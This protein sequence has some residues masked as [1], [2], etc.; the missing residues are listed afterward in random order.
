MKIYNIFE[1]IVEPT[2]SEVIPTGADIVKVQVQSTGSYSVKF[3]GR[4]SP[5]FEYL[6]VK[7][8]DNE[9]KLTDNITKN[10]L[11]TI[12]LS[13]FTEFYIEAETV[14]NELSLS[15]NFDVK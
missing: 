10:G 15:L 12:N 6:T 9:E 2:T 4:M 8:K 11:Y 14:P 3:M 5:K 7:A 13:G 1:K